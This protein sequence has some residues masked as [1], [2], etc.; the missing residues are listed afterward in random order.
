MIT[1]LN[2]PLPVTLTAATRPAGVRSTS[3]RGWAYAWI[4]TG[5]D[6]HRLWMVAMDDTGELVDVPQPDLVM[7]AN[8][9]FGRRG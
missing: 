9:S 4:D 8:W 6:A 3:A 7:D 2:P 1:Q 5:I